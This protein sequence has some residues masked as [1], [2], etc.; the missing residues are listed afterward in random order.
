M[1]ENREKARAKPGAEGKGA[2]AGEKRKREVADGSDDG[3]ENHSH[4]ED[5]SAQEGGKIRKRKRKRKGAETSRDVHQ[6]QDTDES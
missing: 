2:R 5:G 3:E 4:Q 1:L 6:P